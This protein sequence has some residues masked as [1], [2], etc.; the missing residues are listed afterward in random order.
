MFSSAG[1]Y[2]TEKFIIFNKKDE[3][4]GIKKGLK[5]AIKSASD[6]KLSK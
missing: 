6:Q 3:I 2:T 5:S 1:R 4:M